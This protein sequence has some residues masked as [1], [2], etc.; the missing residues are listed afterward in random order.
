MVAPP[1]LAYPVAVR[2]RLLLLLL[3][4]MFGACAGA[5]PHG[6]PPVPIEVHGVEAAA[7]VVRCVVTPAEH[8]PE[9]G[10]GRAVDAAAQRQLLRQLGVQGLT[11]ACSGEQVLVAVVAPG[12]PRL[13]LVTIGSEEGVDVIT[14]VLGARREAPDAAA[15]RTAILL[16]VERRPHQLAIVCRDLAHDTE[17][18]LAVFDGS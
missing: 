7:I 18:T 6:C 16:W 2:R 10:C 17:K 15:A 11:E 1:G 9:P 5:M 13:E 3:P 14:L 12:A 4:T 8:V